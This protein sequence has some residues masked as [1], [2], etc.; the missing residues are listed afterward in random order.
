MAKLD[1]PVATVDG[2]VWTGTNGVVY[3]YVGTPP[4][5]YWQGITGEYAQDSNANIH[6]GDTPPLD[7]EPGNLWWDSSNDSGRLYMF[8]EDVDSSQ[9]VEASPSGTGE[10]GE[11]GE[12]TLWD[13]NGNDLEPKV[14]TDNVV[15]GGDKITLNATDGS[16][17]F[18]GSTLDL[19]A[20]TLFPKLRIARPTDG[21]LDLAYVGFDS[22]FVT[23]AGNDKNR[24]GIVN[25]SGEGQVNV[26]IAE[27][28]SFQV[29]AYDL[30][31]DTFT[32]VARIEIDGT[33]RIGGTLPGTPNI[34]LASNGSATFAGDVKSST[35]VYAGGQP[36][37]GTASGVRL[38]SIGKIYAARAGGI[39]FEGYTTGDSSA[40]IV[41]N[42]NGSAT[43]A[44]PVEASSS[45]NTTGAIKI[46]NAN[47]GTGANASFLA[48][49]GT[50]TASFG[51]GGTNYNAYAGIR[52]NG[53][54]V[55]SHQPEGIGF[56][57]DNASGY[58]NFFTGPGNDERLRIDSSGDVKIGGTLPSAPNIGLYNDGSVVGNVLV[59]AGGDP[60]GSKNTGSRLYNTGLIAGSAASGTSPVFQG[61][62]TTGGNTSATSTISAD[63][64]ATFSKSVTTSEFV[65]VRNVDST[66]AAVYIGNA[67]GNP[68]RSNL[69]FEIAPTLSS[70]DA[71]TKINYDGSA[72]FSGNVTADNVTFNLEAD[73]PANYTTTTDSEGVETQVYNGPVLDVKAL[74][75]T[76]QTAASRIESLETAKASLEARL[77][78]LEG[79]N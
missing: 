22:R 74:L 34:T 53:A 21:R 30:L 45:V 1:F 32:P 2:Q 72:T 3:T 4:N 40:K 14:A 55:Y 18:T 68:A 44:G 78:A 57:A 49:N 43:F 75:L 69:A 66:L 36:A 9:W 60:S 63:G 15:I 59:Q 19:G 5:G 62:T 79:A 12:P 24:F 61:F 7:P 41:M 37:S 42:S 48:S 31:S 58:I 27:P 77:T 54:F 65:N 52:P 10:D 46:T 39:I 50:K 16:G 6:V 11:D 25:L 38:Q 67:D 76:L 70:S 33:L 71:T 29:Q 51:I 17:T 13:K 8:Y 56:T 23:D 20:S 64:G 28:G 47:A 26:G 73:N 35:D